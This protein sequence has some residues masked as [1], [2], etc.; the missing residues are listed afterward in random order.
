MQL[1]GFQ[2]RYVAQIT[3]FMTISELVLKLTGGT[4]QSTLSC[5]TACSI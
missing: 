4:R 3:H 5:C 1:S 2:W